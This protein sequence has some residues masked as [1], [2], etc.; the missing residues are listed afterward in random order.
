[1]SLEAAC[2]LSFTDLLRVL[3]EKLG[4]EY[5]R[6]QGTR[7]PPAVSAASLEPEVSAPRLA[8]VVIGSNPVSHI[9]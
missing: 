7:L 9:D 2:D 5:T 3:S 1:M 8:N 6:L 4:R